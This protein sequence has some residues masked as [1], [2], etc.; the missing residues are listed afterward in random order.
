M[1]PTAGYYAPLGPQTVSGPVALSPVTM[2]AS[3]ASPTPAPTATASTATI[4]AGPRPVATYYHVNP[5]DTL[6]SIATR[7]G[8]TVDEIRNANKLNGNN[9]LAPGQMVL[10]P[11]EGT[12]IR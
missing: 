9:D 2:T 5:G 7:Y 8:K 12:L 11:G 4:P 6:S 1:A 3:T 10:I